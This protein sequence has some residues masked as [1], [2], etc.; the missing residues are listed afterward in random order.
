MTA[1]A[2]AAAAVVA[3]MIAHDD[4]KVK[5]EEGA[6]KRVMVKGRLI[7]RDDDDHDHDKKKNGDDG[8]ENNKKKKRERMEAARIAPLARAAKAC[9]LESAELLEA[10]KKSIMMPVPLRNRLRAIARRALL[11]KHALKHAKHAPKPESARVSDDDEVEGARQDAW[12]AYYAARGERQQRSLRIM[13]YLRSEAL[14]EAKPHMHA[15]RAAA[16]A[17]VRINER[18]QSDAE[19]IRRGAGARGYHVALERRGDLQAQEEH[20]PY[21][22]ASE[23]DP[24]PGFTDILRAAQAHLIDTERCLDGH[25]NNDQEDQDHQDHHVAVGVVVMDLLL[26]TS[27]TSSTASTTAPTAPAL[28]FEEDINDDEE[29]SSSDDDDHDD[30]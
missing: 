11:L 18:L 17:L 21:L 5:E 4:K 13:R 30:E 20:E 3:T 9:A 23:S 10:R 27:S 6:L 14:R 1:S 2:A 19:A 12:D 8:G 26:L 24:A 29:E 16:H 28:P 15:L 25:T 22:R 7:V